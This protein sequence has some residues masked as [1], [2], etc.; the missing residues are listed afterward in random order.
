TM[1]A[2][3]DGAVRVMLV[4]DGRSVACRVPLDG[5]A[6]T[7]EDITP[8]TA[9]FPLA[10]G[11]RLAK[12]EGRQVERRVVPPGLSLDDPSAR[13]V[14][15]VGAFW[16]TSDG[17][18]VVYSA[19][20]GIVRHDVESGLEK[21]LTGRVPLHWRSISPDGKTIYAAPELGFVRRQLVTNFGER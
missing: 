20:E 2:C 6:A 3:G 15:T 1:I 8:W 19:R 4:R 13:K 10:G 7:E 21:L 16:W 9:V 17:R 12:R 14:A 5:G 18:A 11:W